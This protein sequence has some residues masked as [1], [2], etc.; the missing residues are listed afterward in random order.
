MVSGI[1]E[2]NLGPVSEVSAWGAG[3]NSRTYRATLEGGTRVLAKRYFKREGEARDRLDVEYS[4]LAFLNANGVDALPR[5]LARDD[6][7]RFALYEFLEGGLIAP[8]DVLP[9]HAAAAGGFSGALARASRV[10]GARALPPAS[11]A[12]LSIAAHIGCVERRLTRLL[13]VIG[14][15]PIDQ[16]A[17]AFLETELR[18]TYEEASRRAQAGATAAGLEVAVELPIEAQTLSPSDYG[19]HNAISTPGGVKFI[20]LEYAGWDD[21]AK[22]VADFFQQPRPLARALRPAF[23]NAY[24]EDVPDALRLGGLG[25]SAP[26]VEVVLDH[27]QRV[28]S[29]GGSAP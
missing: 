13:S 15:D 5:A 4:V 21:P 6:A 17:R 24:L 8:G 14:S 3:A 26:G 28:P 22:M 27:A 9:E 20:D 25:P 2:A 10:P 12:C 1:V 16:Q 7:N 19:F 29:A 23:L 11:E 18:P